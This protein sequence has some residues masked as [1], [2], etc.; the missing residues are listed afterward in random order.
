[1]Y[2]HCTHHSVK[3]KILALFTSPSYLRVVIAFGMGVECSDVRQETGR[4]GKDGLP[5]C[6]LLL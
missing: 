3:D 1:M 2:T 5:S 4:A 6:A